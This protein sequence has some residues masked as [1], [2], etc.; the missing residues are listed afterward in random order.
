VGKE[1]IEP[2][3]AIDLI[4]RVPG[5]A[6]PEVLISTE[7]DVGTLNDANLAANRV[8]SSHKDDKAKPDGFRIT[9]LRT[10]E[11]VCTWYADGDA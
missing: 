6:T 3:F 2:M 9:N 11:V 10:K 1:D 5:S 7:P 4:R 8:F